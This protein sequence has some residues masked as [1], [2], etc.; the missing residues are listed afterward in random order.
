MPLKCADRL[1]LSSTVRAYRKLNSATHN[2]ADNTGCRMTF[3]M[4]A[5]TLRSDASVREAMSGGGTYE[6]L[7]DA[8]GPPATETRTDFATY[9]LGAKLACF[10][11]FLPRPTSRAIPHYI[12]QGAMGGLDSVGFGFVHMDFSQ[13]PRNCAREDWC[14]SQRSTLKRR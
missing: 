5:A 8:G 1:Y 3:I 9:T 10:L 2:K 6:R 14:C 4:H 13:L 7:G 12:N 11:V